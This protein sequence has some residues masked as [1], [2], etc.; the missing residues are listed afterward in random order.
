MKSLTVEKPNPFENALKTL[1]QANEFAGVRDEIFAK[2]IQP[3]HIHKFEI[4]VG[5][6]K[7]QG[8]RVQH[9]SARGPYKGGIRFHPQVDI[10]EVKALATW[11][12]LK[13]AVADIPYGGG[14]GGVACNPKVMS[15]KELEAVSRGWAK[16][17]ALHIGAWKDVP[18][19]DVNTDGQI[20]A[21]I[22]DEF[23]KII[24]KREPAAITGKPLELGG[25]LG[26]DKATSQGGFFILREAMKA[27]KLKHNTVAI[28]GL[29]NVG[30]WL[31]EI[32][33][34][35]KFKVVAVSDSRGAIYNEKG[36]DIPEVL[37]HKESTGTVTGFP[38]AK[39]II[40]ED[41]LMLPVE[42][43]APAALENV[44]TSEN[45]DNIK[46]KLVLEMANGPTTPEA[47]KIL[48]SKGVKVIPD[49]LANAGGVT[50]SYF[51]W[52]QNL[53]GYYWDLDEV[54]KRLEKKMTQAFDD[55]HA[56]AQKYKISYRLAANVLALERIAKAMELRGW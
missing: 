42:I 26:R 5:T 43:I 27:N 12:S 32:L 11:M 21:W 17:M 30:G 28:Q 9:N 14:K 40:N 18:A 7:Y 54:D 50:V 45:A 10:D 19:P 55:V 37:K 15:K 31:A 35:E 2:I 3:E 8:Y 38:G 1:Q 34:K 13:C 52:V 48:E 46:A 4:P 25:S 16:A 24:G 39:E 29:G 23:E 56:T 51:E 53:A 36:L 47:D 49:I 22:L 6:K 33:H 41:I 20:M 44:I